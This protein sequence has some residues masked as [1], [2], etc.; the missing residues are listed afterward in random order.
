M[1]TSDVRTVDDLIL[2]QYAKVMARAA[3]GPDAKKEAFGFVR[4]TY[5]KLKSGEKN[6][7]DIVREDKQL[8]EAPKACAYCG[9]T[10]GLQWEHIVPRSL[11]VRPECAS[12][13][14][15]QGIHNQ[16]WACAACNQAKSD[17]G[18]YRF[19]RSKFPEDRHFYDRIPAL[20]EKKYLKTVRE[21]HG[22]AGTLHREKPGI[23][24]EDLDVA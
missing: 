5:R 16:V 18:L 13:E 2:Y 7:S 20:V 8:V 4:A 17:M 10:E 14:T 12:C 22:C 6:L 1:P 9:A 24:Q 23:A 3:F 21:C 15:L 11:R 19:F